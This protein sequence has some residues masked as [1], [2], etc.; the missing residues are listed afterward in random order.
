MQKEKSKEGKP[1]GNP[2]S[3]VIED[4]VKIQWR[5]MKTEVLRFQEFKE[6]LLSAY[7]LRP[8]MKS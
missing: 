1:G 3:Q 6:G 2:A 5:G 8:S 4:D 7:G